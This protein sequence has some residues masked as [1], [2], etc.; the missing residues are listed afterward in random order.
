MVN[1]I[2]AAAG[3]PELFAVIDVEV[4]EVIARGMS[5]EQANGFVMAVSRLHGEHFE[6]VPEAI[7]WPTDDQVL[8]QL[9]LA[10]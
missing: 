1:R 5:R 7:Q 2:K 9:Q 3:V 4:P 6:S 10:R 8:G